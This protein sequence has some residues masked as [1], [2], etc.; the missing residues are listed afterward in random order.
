MGKL[1]TALHSRLNSTIHSMGYE[2]VGGEMLPQGKRMVLRLYIDGASPD[3][4]VTADDCSAVSRQVGAMLDAED[5]IQ[6]QYVLEVSSPGIDRPLFTL[7]Q[8]QKFIGS[9]IH[10]RLHAPQDGRRQF[11]GRLVRIEGENV[12]LEVD[13]VE[14]EIRLPFSMI[15]KANIVAEISF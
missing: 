10:V 15:E 4:R 12:F 3:K 5:L 1:N 7:D 13:N 14:H 6:S 9:R 2:F 8:Y 11:K